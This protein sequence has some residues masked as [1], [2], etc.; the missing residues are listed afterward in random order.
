MKRSFLLVNAFL[1][2]GAVYACSSDETTTNP[3]TS[4]D[5]GSGSETSTAADSGSTKDSGGGSDAAT[6]V[7]TGVDAAVPAPCTDAELDLPANDYSAFDGGGLGQVDIAFPAS[8]GDGVKQYTNRCVKIKAG[9]K[10]SF[11]GAFNLHPLTPFG[12]TTPSPIPANTNVTPDAGYLEVTFPN[13]G[14]YG[15]RC[16]FHPLVMNGAVKVVP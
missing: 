1:A 7:D 16:G 13:P 8:L 4:T 12:G 6:V 5:A 3:A 15:Y 10:V 9:Q 11:G 14:T 2:L